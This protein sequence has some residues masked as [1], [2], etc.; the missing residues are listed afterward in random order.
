MP[1][2]TGIVTRPPCRVIDR[3]RTLRPPGATRFVRFRRR[4]QLRDR[5][6]KGFREVHKHC[7]RHVLARLDALKSPRVDAESFCEMFLRPTAQAAKLRHAPSHVRHD[8][9]Q[10]HSATLDAVVQRQ[11]TSRVVAFVA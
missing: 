2:S 8:L 9:R 1:F 7:E 10:F 5:N 6:P 3:R 4:K 11:N